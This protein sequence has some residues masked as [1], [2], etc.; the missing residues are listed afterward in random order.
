MAEITMS[1]IQDEEQSQKVRSAR[2]RRELRMEFSSLVTVR[3]WFVRYV[4][5]VSSVADELEFYVFSSVLLFSGL[6]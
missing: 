3:F 2:V 5:R 6:C 4:E 1:E